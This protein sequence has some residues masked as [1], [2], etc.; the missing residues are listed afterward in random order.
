[1]VNEAETRWAL[2]YNGYERFAGGSSGSDALRRLL[3]P[4]MREY[5]AT[6]RVPD[7]CGVDLLRAWAFYRQ[8]EHH[9]DGVSP[10]A[11]DWDAVLDAIRRHPAATA[12][13][14]PPTA[15]GEEERG[16]PSAGDAVETARSAALPL[17]LG[18]V[19]AAV[20][21]DHAPPI[22]LDD[23]LV[24]RHAFKP[25]G[26]VGLQG[27]EDV[28]EGR[29]HDYTRSQDIS[30][31]KFP[32]E[33]PRYWVILVADGKSRSRLFGVYENHGEQL[34][35][36]T[37]TNRFWD[38]RRVDFLRS[39]EDRLVVDWTSPRSWYR[40]GPSAATLPV[41]EIADRDAI[42]FPGFDR[43]LLRWH[44]LE[45]LVGDSRYAAWRAALSEVQG[46]YLIT[47]SS[48][49]KQYVGKAD[50]AERLIGRWSAYAKNG[51][52]GNVALRELAKA[53]R[54]AGTTLDG[55]AEDHARHFVFSIL[56][57]FGPS[58]PP[59]EVDAAESHFKSALMT[60]TW[61]LNRN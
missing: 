53:A 27:P 1:M 5:E 4:A 51:H 46:I 15:V 22:G 60:R 49:G 8:R 16:E 43:V 58:T 19:L 44:E 10:M 39:L 26:H 36:K 25:S 47:D 30:T 29:L 41:L 2:E 48:T 23:I 40:W 21:A 38:L 28:T 45:E 7:W 57:V 18:H 11:R 50:G 32:A 54:E 13:D 56:R 42:E 33:P 61:G 31:R 37:E 59:S 12:W 24:I 17:T 6:G 52:G 14:L 55:A 34:E 9:M 20:G 35:E 3:Q